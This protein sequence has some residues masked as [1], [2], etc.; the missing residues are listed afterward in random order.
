M[1][2]FIDASSWKAINSKI[3]AVIEDFAFTGKTE[4]LKILPAIQPLSCVHFCMR[5]FGFA[6]LLFPC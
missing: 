2:S 1:A 5:M 6:L 4:N 3:K